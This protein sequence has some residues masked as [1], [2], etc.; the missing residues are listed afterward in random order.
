M[1]FVALPWSMLLPA[2]VMLLLGRL[3]KVAWALVVAGCAL[4]FV[5][6]QLRPEALP[7]LAALGL[8]GVAIQPPRSFAL[9]IMGH[10]VFVLLALALRAHVAPGFN[11]PLVFDAQVS[12]GASVHRA[13]L[14]LDKLLVGLW[15]MAAWPGIDWAANRVEALRMGTTVGLVTAAI[16]IGISWEIGLIAWDPKYPP[17][18]AIWAINMVLLVCFCEEV[19]FR[20]YIQSGLTHVFRRHAQGANVALL[21]S[22]VVFG[23][24]HLDGGW[25]YALLCVVAASGYG[26]AYRRGGLLASIAAHATLNLLHFFLFTYPALDLDR[27]ALATSS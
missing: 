10:L 8:A 3:Q 16:C 7:V 5:A 19:V 13:Y 14:N 11:N 25:R 4:A 27:H 24:A 17:G 23:L 15:L 6:E 18:A 26:I 9:R 12:S 22:A 20:G 21:V 1:G 2:L